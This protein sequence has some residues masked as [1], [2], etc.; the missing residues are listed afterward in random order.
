MINKNLRK[1]AKLLN[2]FLT[3]PDQVEKY[4]EIMQSTF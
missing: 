3:T 4:V 1:V 2:I